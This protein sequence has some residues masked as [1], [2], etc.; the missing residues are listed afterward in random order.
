VLSSSRAGSVDILLAASL[1]GTT[2]TVRTF[3]AVGPIE[4]GAAKTIL[5]GVLLATFAA[6]GGRLHALLAGGRR[7]WVLLAL[8][9]LC[10]ADFQLA[11]F[12]AVVR[13]GVATGTVVTI[14]SAPV[15]SGLLAGV[16]DH[17]RPSRR[18]LVSTA[19]A[20]TGCALLVGGGQRAGVEPLGVGLALL[21]GLGYAA[22][23]TIAGRLIRAGADDR[24]VIGSLFAGAAVLLLP[25][26]VLGS[27]APM[28][29]VPGA[30]VTLYL[31]VITTAVPYVLYAR[32][33]RST[34]VPVATTLGLAEPAVAALLGLTVL[35]EHLAPIALAGIALLAAALVVLIA[36]GR[37]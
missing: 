3:S 16:L 25:A 28:A 7:T 15:L 29:T 21:S 32:G 9:A 2:G 20:V 4:G 22:Y 27:L 5:G 17:R 24:A 12:A 1:W 11:F 14:G 35:G 6:R 34:P 26:L 36:P 19:A 13:T 33:L 30:L 37:H 8:G 31:G 18:W 23:A 10:V